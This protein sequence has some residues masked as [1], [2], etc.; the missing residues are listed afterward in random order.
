V[1]DS[2]LIEHHDARVAPPAGRPQQAECGEEVA[3]LVELLEVG[4]AVHEG[5]APLAESL[6]HVVALLREHARLVHLAA[7]AL[8]APIQGDQLQ[9][10]LV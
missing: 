6:P 5:A 7:G 9:P 3:L 10:L 2:E 4:T 1:G 8:D